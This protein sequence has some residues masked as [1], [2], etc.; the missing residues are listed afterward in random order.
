MLRF[1]KALIQLLI[2]GAIVSPNSF[3]LLGSFMRA[4]EVEITT[5]VSTAAPASID[6][7][8]SLDKKRYAEWKSIVGFPAQVV[9]SYICSWPTTT[10]EFCSEAGVSK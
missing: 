4:Y 7:E 6:I 8:L 9:D 3:G 5:T 1:V 10:L 2:L